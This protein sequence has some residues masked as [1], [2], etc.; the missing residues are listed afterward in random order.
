MKIKESQRAYFFMWKSTGTRLLPLKPHLKTM[1]ASET[2]FLGR[3]HGFL[4][5][6]TL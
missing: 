6:N 4:H 2:T 1:M 5:R 3:M